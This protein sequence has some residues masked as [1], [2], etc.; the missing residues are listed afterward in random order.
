M[1][2]AEASL[3]T[4]DPCTTSVEEREEDKQDPFLLAADLTALASI[5]AKNAESLSAETGMKLES[6][7][8][9]CARLEAECERVLEQTQE[10]E[11]PRE[12]P[13]QPQ[14]EVKESSPK[15]ATATPSSYNRASEPARFVPKVTRVTP[16]P[17]RLLP[18]KNNSTLQEKTHL[19]QNRVD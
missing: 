18:K 10:Q 17:T 5:H 16:K 14:P 4:N 13:P 1:E 7:L 9:E 19:S 15:Q 12:E 2:V 11:K 3:G 8:K 6:I